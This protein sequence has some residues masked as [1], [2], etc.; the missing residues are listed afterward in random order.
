MRWKGI[1]CQY[2]FVKEGQNGG[3]V[4]VYIKGTESTGKSYRATV[5]S[6]HTL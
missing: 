5:S 4:L 3:A 1:L 2:V 6:S